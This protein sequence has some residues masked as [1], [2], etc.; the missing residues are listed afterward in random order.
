VAV[1]CR[2]L[3]RGACCFYASGLC[4]TPDF[5]DGFVKSDLF[6][7]GGIFAEKNSEKGSYCHFERQQEILNAQD[8]SSL[9]FLEMTYWQLFKIIEYII[10]SFGSPLMVDKMQ[11]GF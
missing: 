3:V 10:E 5:Y 4:C 9:S 8:C 7:R 1:V 6:R 2:P 11:G